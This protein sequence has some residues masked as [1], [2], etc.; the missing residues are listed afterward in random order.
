MKNVVREY[1]QLLLAVGIVVIVAAIVM[2]VFVRCLG[3]AAK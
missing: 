2:F 1:L 3:A